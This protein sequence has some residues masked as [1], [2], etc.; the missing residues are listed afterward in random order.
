M[1][2][3]RSALL[4]LLPAPALAAQHPRAQAPHGGA[5][6]QPPAPRGG[7][8]RVEARL[9]PGGPPVAIEVAPATIARERVQRIAAS[10]A[11]AGEVILPSLTGGVGSAAVL[12]LAGREVVVVNMAGMTG[13]GIAQQLGAVI[14]A[15]EQ[16]RLRIIGL[17]NL[18]A[19][20]NSTCESEG[21]L[22]GRFEP[23]EDGTLGFACAFQRVRGSCGQRWA[24][25]ARREG[26]TDVLAWDGRGA[27]RGEPAPDDA[28]RLR[29]AVANARE[30][31]ASLLT[32]VVTDL[33]RVDWDATGVTDLVLL[34]LA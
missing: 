6:A 18:D 23:G 19:R 5:A 21:R 25:P 10:G 26:W 12:P 30:K 20:E 16:G 29:H 32:P 31:V 34:G 2:P 28:S 3:R 22:T 9:R 11:L 7:G 24:G 14:A 27:L 15:D 8:R 4:L 33:R 13:T 1:I 17:E